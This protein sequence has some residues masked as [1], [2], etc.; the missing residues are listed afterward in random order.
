MSIIAGARC[1]CKKPAK[2]RLK[3]SAAFSNFKKQRQEACCVQKCSHSC[4]VSGPLAWACY[5]FLEA[6]GWTAHDT[7]APEHTSG[8]IQH[9]CLIPAWPEHNPATLTSSAQPQPAA[10]PC[11]PTIMMVPLYLQRCL[12]YLLKEKAWLRAMSGLTQR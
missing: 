2:A 11:P 9:C 10:S 12:L 3:L 5:V 1:E 4:V 7:R 6:T 8:P